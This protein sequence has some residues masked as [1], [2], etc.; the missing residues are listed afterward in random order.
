MSIKKNFL[1]SSILTSAGYIFPLITYPYVSRVLG[2]SNIGI[3]NFVDSVINYFLLFAM[4]GIRTIG[5]R[6]IARCQ[7]NKEEMSRTFFSVFLLN[8]L[9]VII[10]G[11]LLLISIQIVPQFAEHKQLMYIGVMK[12]L[13]TFLMVEW[14]FKGVEDFKYITKRSL[15]IRCFYVISVFIFVRKPDDYPVYFFLLI[16]TE[17]INALIN[18]IYAK[19]YIYF[20]VRNLHP[21]AYFKS[22]LI[23]GCYGLLTT[24]YTT[25]NVVY[26]GFVSTPTQVGY[27]TTA[28]KLHH[29][30][31]AFFTAFTGVMM[32]RMSHYLSEGNCKEFGKKIHDSLAILI[33]TSFPIMVIGIFFAPEII[34]IISGSGYEGA[35]PSLVIVMPLIFIIGAEQILVMQTLMPLKK[36]RAILIN[37]LAGALVGIGLNFLL[38]SHWG[39]SGSAIVW[40]CSELSVMT[41]AII[42]VRKS[43]SFSGV[44]KKI[45]K[46]LL[47]AIPPVIVC[48]IL[49][50]IE[51]NAFVS[52]FLAML[53]IAIYYSYMYLFVIK[54]SVIL[55]LLPKRLNI[56]KR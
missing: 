8:L 36:D 42:F 20:T 54:D 25:F 38:V 9:F 3:C 41:S 12:L 55:S 44:T 28:T 11:G 6:E 33:Y 45:T 4:M 46:N 17:A 52:L 14:L 26:L 16:S 48:L 43:V 5:I 21:F 27:Y 19:K 30:I 13:A 35:I 29:I 23:L 50:V 51:I 7:G 47:L 40:L 24:M 15:I 39:S 18:C 37:S 2:V 31:L 1:Y 56:Q 32:P 22:S 34:R 53:A 10:F 49:R